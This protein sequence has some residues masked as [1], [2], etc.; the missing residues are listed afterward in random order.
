MKDSRRIYAAFSIYINIGI[1]EYFPQSLT[2]IFL[3]EKR[4]PAPPFKIGFFQLIFTRSLS[5][6]PRKKSGIS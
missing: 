5:S 2:T 4:R 6:S 3:K 1:E